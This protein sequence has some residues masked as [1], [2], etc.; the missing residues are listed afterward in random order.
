MLDV[1]PSS[2]LPYPIITF[3]PSTL[4]YLYSRFAEQHLHVTRYTPSIRI[5]ITFYTT[6]AP[7]DD[8][9]AP[10]SAPKL[11]GRR[12]TLPPEPT[13]FPVED[14]PTAAP[15]GYDILVSSYTITNKST[16]PF[17]LLHM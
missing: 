7:D 4:C 9:D 11:R 10:D 5:Y 3:T 6:C 12:H 15:V 8:V 14:Q 17:G 16:T 13:S 2:L 1:T